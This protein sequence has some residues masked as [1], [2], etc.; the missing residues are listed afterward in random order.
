V[1]FGGFVCLETFLGFNFVYLAS[2]CS[3]LT[4]CPASSYPANYGVPAFEEAQDKAVCATIGNS[5]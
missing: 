2:R 3:C 5:R 1:S 4:L